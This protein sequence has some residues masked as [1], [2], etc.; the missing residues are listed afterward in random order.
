MAKQRRQKDL[1]FDEMPNVTGII[2][3]VKEHLPAKTLHPTQPH[4]IA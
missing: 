4:V 3:M 1:T 2:D